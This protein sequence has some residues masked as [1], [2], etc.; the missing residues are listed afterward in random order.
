MTGHPSKKY[1]L[2]VEDDAS[3]CRLMKT[4]LD[5]NGYEVTVVGHGLDA[6]KAIERK[7]PDL[8]I[9]DVC[10]PEMDG[11][12][13]LK[14][15]KKI[16]TASQV[17]V[18]ILTARK[19]MEDTF[20]VLGV[21]EF[22]VKPFSSEELLAR[23]LRLVTRMRTSAPAAADLTTITAAKDQKSYATI[24]GIGVF[25][26][27]MVLIVVALI[28]NLLNMSSSGKSRLNRGAASG[29]LEDVD[30]SNLGQESP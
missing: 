10:M 1:V 12:I 15:L 7:V 9:S 28:H 30:L 25:L 14:E 3:T 5:N 23:V 19:G 6:L 29:N 26:L 2:I 18:M 13:F 17:P 20:M 16:P 24:I 22:L 11:F 21:D 8:I 27:V 4:L